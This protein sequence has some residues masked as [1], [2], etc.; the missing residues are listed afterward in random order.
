[1]TAEPETLKSFHLHLVSDSTGDTL[2]NLARACV[3]QFENVR[4]VEHVWRLVRGE[5]K[6]N[7]VIDD[8]ADHPGIVLFT[9][10]DNGTRQLLEE[11]CR[12]LGVPCI[13][14]MDPV[15]GALA[16]FLEQE[17]GEM[18]GQQYEINSAYFRRLEAMKY[19]IA[20]D[21]GVLADDLDQADI[22][23]VGV[24][25]TSKTPTSI[26][27]AQKGLKVANVPMVPNVPLPDTL[28]KLDGPMI[29]GLT[30]D[31]RDLTDIRENRLKVM[32]ETHETDYAEIE[33]VTEEIRNARRLF[34]KHRWPV[35][36]T[37]HKSI[38]E[39]CAKILAFHTK[40]LQA[41]EETDE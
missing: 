30:R 2:T 8:I 15:L 29:I 21:D 28:F 20:H 39:V 37:S 6:I 5:A 1:M 12:H 13:A 17:V 3:V 41:K 14:V 26:F 25:R 7:T 9:I 22:V 40:H 27:L 19:S 24:S 10:V 36:S 18:P 4:P 11:A 32:Q 34:A 23:L 16:G 31:P 33:A 38:E 35:V